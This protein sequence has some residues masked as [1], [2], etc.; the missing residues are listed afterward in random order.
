MNDHSSPGSDLADR[1]E[2]AL[3]VSLVTETATGSLLSTPLPDNEV[4]VLALAL[5][6]AVQAASEP[7]ERHS[8]PWI[9]PDAQLAR[10]CAIAA[11]RDYGTDDPET[12]QRIMRDGVWNDHVAVQAALAAIHNIRKRDAVPQASKIVAWCWRLKGNT[13][14]WIGDQV[15]TAISGNGNWEIEPLG[16][17]QPQAV[18]HALRTTRF[19]EVSCEKT[20]SGCEWPECDCKKMRGTFACPICGKD[21]PH[22][23][24]VEKRAECSGCMNP[25]CEDCFDQDALSRPKQG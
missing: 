23:H 6:T 8:G 7:V 2:K 3:A 9:G 21:T 22:H 24:D 11:I 17:I 19:E 5:R 14:W 12:H 18:W 16:F 4:A 13:D 1:I 10:D 25:A 15:P 20:D